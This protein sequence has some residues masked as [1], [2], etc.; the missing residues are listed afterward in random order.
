[1]KTLATLLL[2]AATPAMA[3]TLD[4]VTFPDKVALEGK[5]LQLNGIATRKATIFKVKVY[6]GALY[7]ESPSSDAQ[8]VVA[9][10]QLKRIQMQ[11]V[12]DVGSKD[13]HKTWRENYEKNCADACEADKAKLE[14]L[15]GYLSADVKSGDQTTYNFLPG[16]VEVFVGA[17]KKGVI[18]GATMARTIL[19]SY[20]GPKVADENLRD[21]LL[22]KKH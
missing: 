6:V 2:L 8:A 22:G 3:A 11:F 18:E 10:P 15:L 17:E 12:R 19:L 20:L 5:A 21:G 1:M 4:G 13:I 7:L 14:Q 9:S 16:K